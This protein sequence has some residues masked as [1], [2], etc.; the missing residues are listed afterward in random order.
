MI[1]SYRAINNPSARRKWLAFVLVILF[2]GFGYTAFKIATGAGLGRSVIVAAVFALFV[3]LY[4][5]ITLGKPR[6]YYI[7]ENYVYYR[8]FKTDLKKIKGFE[9]DVNG[10]VIKLHGAGILGVRTLYFDSVE[11]LNEV[12]RRLEKI[13]G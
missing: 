1:W 9:V 5:I 3:S 13:K 12:R 8:P 11:D 2:L 6:Y 4:A 7:D 10:R